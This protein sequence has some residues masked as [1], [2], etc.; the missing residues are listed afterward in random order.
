MSRADRFAFLISLIGVLLAVFITDHIF[1][2]MAHL[3]DEIAYVWQA[4]AI[5][6][7]ELKLPSPPD[8]H[9]FLVPFVVD[10]H[11]ERFGKYPLGWPALLA[12]GI[13]LGGRHLVNPLLSGLALWLIYRLGKRIFGETV[14]LLA[15]G[16]TLTS[17]FFLVNSGSLLS[18]PFGLVLSTSFV[19][20]WLASWETDPRKMIKPTTNSWL[21]SILAAMALGVLGLTRPLTALALCLPFAVHGLYLFFRGNRQVRIQLL[22][23][24]AILIGLGSLHFL[25]QYAVSGDPW[26]NPYT[27]WWPYDKVGFGPGFG[28]V[29]GGHTLNQAWVNTRHSLWVGWHD[30]FGWGAY[31]WIFLPFGLISVIRYRQGRALLLASVYPILVVVYLAYWIGS[32]LFGPR[33]Y[34][35]GLYSL[36]LVSAAGIA[37]LAG[38]PTHPAEDWQGKAGWWRARP[39]LITALL[40]VLLAGNMLFYTPMRLESMRRLYGVERSRLQPFLT[41]EAQSLTPALVVVHPDKWTEYGALLEL[42][43]PFLDTPFIFVISRGVRA[44]NALKGKFPERTILHYY[45]D[46]PYTLY[47][48][49]R[50]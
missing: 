28:R 37:Y 2:R 32:S 31:S 38:W 10:Y 19:L 34:F 8:P 7:G 39:L 47:K 4:Q 29:E 13:F 41:P 18:H 45:P 9:S 46:E 5:S 49:S 44:D 15:A 6:R 43:D 17:P 40:T 27:L 30:L 16:L 35:E 20:A 11:G 21:S 3:E 22:A 26:L 33:Y 24:C 23:F 1:E 25:W 50:P 12:V 36:T 48:T 14:G 42:Q